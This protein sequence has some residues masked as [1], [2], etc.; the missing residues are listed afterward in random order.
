MLRELQGYLGQAQSPSSTLPPRSILEELMADASA[1]PVACMRPHAARAL[2]RMH[3]TQALRVCS[4]APSPALAA[5]IQNGGDKLDASGPLV[6]SELQDR[7]LMIQ[8]CAKTAVNLSIDMAESSSRMSRTATQQ[9]ETEA[10]HGSPLLADEEPY[11][12]ALLEEEGDLA[13]GM[14]AAAG[15][16][17]PGPDPGVQPNFHEIALMMAAVLAG[18]EKESEAM[19]GAERSD[20]GLPLSS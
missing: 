6:A 1:F 5:F 7:Y 17:S 11:S 12:A 10:Q 18:V 19:V 20:T 15:S 3:V 13:P 8:N 2:Q 9:H 16:R 4:Q 14:M